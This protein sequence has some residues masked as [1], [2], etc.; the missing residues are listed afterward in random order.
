[1]LS[2]GAGVPLR[3]GLNLC[4]TALSLIA[5]GSLSLSPSS[6]IGSSSESSSTLI[7]VVSFPL[8][9][10]LLREA[11]LVSTG[12]DLAW[13]GA[14]VLALDR[15]RSVPGSGSNWLSTYM[16]SGGRLVDATGTYVPGLPLS[17]LDVKMAVGLRAVVNSSH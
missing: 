12:I 8:P 16:V 5:I 10:S 15:G 9:L 3:V 6:T 13:V 7:T 11:P 4:L 2:R 17:F 1:M 14:E